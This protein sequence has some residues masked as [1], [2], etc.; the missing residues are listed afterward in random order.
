LVLADI[1]DPLS[2]IGIAAKFHIGA[3]L[4]IISLS[5]YNYFITSS[6]IIILSGDPS[7]LHFMI[8]SEVHRQ[9]KV[10]VPA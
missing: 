10:Q 5:Q 7:H 2:V 1:S 9:A 3:S 6:V 4:I 8:A